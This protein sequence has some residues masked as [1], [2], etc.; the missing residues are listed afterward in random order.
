MWSGGVGQQQ[1]LCANTRNGGL[2]MV[3]REPRSEQ[4][5]AK[6]VELL[7]RRVLC[8]QQLCAGVRAAELVV[9][10]GGGFG[11]HLAQC[12]EGATWMERGFGRAELCAALQHQHVLS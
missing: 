1:Q 2:Q 11:V 12:L 7:V 9:W 3:L 4:S 5:K 10:R 8:V 6:V